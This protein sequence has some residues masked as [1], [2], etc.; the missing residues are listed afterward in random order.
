MSEAL[1]QEILKIIAI[2]QEHYT[3]ELA[4]GALVAVRVLREASD[5]P[6]LQ[7]AHNAR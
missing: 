3:H 1:V 2:S 5:P 4:H 7:T 6:T